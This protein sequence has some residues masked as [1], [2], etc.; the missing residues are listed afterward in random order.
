MGNLEQ[1]DLGMHSEEQQSPEEK[2]KETKRLLGLMILVAGGVGGALGYEAGKEKGTADLHEDKIENTSA[3][4]LARGTPEMENY[5][6]DIQKK[7]QLISREDAVKVADLARTSSEMHDFFIRN[8]GISEEAV[9]AVDQAKIK[10]T[11]SENQ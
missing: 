4:R 10:L 11:L 3:F 5:L 8:P 7:W 2:L 6:A 9:R 1:S